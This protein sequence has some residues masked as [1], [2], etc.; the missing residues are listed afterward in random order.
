MAARRRSGLQRIEHALPY[1]SVTSDPGSIDSFPLNGVRWHTVATRVR[2]LVTENRRD[3]FVAELY[4]FGEMPR[5]LSA[6]FLM[7]EPGADSWQLARMDGTSLASGKVRST[8]TPAV[9][10][11]NFPRA[12]RFN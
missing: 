11:S 12:P 3:R 9:T 10:R 4:H 2:R 6:S 5:E 1:S 8:P 7:L